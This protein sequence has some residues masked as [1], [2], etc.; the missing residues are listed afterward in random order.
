MHCYNEGDLE[1][2]HSYSTNQGIEDNDENIKILMKYWSK[3]HTTT[4]PFF[5]I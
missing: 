5:P 4:V 1:I 2:R 3:L